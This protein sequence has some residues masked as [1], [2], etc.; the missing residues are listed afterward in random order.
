MQTLLDLQSGNLKGTKHLKL[1]CNLTEFPEEILELADTLEILDLSGNKLHQLPK[2]FSKLHQ[3]KIAF[4]SD[5]YFTEFPEVLYHCPKLEM[6][7]FKSNQIRVISEKAIPKQTR[8]LILTNNQIE[9][10]PR[11]IGDCYRLQK[12]GLAGNRLSSLPDEMAN[13]RNLELLRISANQ[14]SHIPK[15]LFELPKLSW[16]AYSANPCQFVQSFEN[17]ISDIN[18]SELTIKELLGQGASGHIYK[19]EYKK[20]DVAIKIFKG[21]VT[22]DGLPS[23][24]MQACIHADKHKNL[25]TVIGKIKGHPEGKDALVMRLLGSEYKNLGKPPDFNTC[26]RDT[27][28]DACEFS[29]SQVLKIFKD[30]CSVSK[31]LHF[32]GIMHGDLYAH[33]I[34]INSMSNAIL[35]D[36]GAATFYSKQTEMANWHEK[37]DVRAFGCLMDDLLIRVKQVDR[38][39][40]VYKALQRIQ[41]QCWS[42]VVT[43]RPNFETIQ[44]LLNNL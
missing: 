22:S 43:E 4:F 20:E 40:D 7:G 26:S 27:F 34:L 9:A 28:D 8:W 31:H 33:N 6:I 36:F 25:T 24:E 30:I 35:G 42:D 19:A 1:S 32:K 23:S 10:L 5:N 41:Q 17:G 29:L 16:L 12:C 15:W 2:Q 11:S 38:T 13:C 39:N 18:W 37:I 21:E 14:I 3:L 44:Q